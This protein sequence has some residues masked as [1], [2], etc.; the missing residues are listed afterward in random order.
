MAQEGVV[1]G[2]PV[3]VCIGDHPG[4]H[5]AEGAPL[6]NS[7]GGVAERLEEAKAGGGT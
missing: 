5:L 4:R 3:A 2:A 7:G 1:K 6:L